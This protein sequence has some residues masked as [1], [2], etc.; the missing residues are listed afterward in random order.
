MLTGAALLGCNL[1][2]S[3]RTLISDLSVIAATAEPTE[4]A[5]GEE[6]L[7]SM[8]VVDPDRLGVDQVLVWTCADLG[9]GCAEVFLVESGAGLATVAPVADEQAQVTLV[10][11]SPLALVFQEGLDELSLPLYILACAPGACPIFDQVAADPAVGTPEF[12]AL[13]EALGDPESLV[14]GLPM[15]QACLA[16]RD[17]LISLRGEEERNHNPLLVGPTEE[18]T[19]VPDE[20][21]ALVFSVGDPDSEEEEATVFL[22]PLSTLGTFD[23][24]ALASAS[25]DVTLSFLAPDDIDGLGLYAVVRDGL[26]GQTWWRGEIA[27]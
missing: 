23:Q 10:V 16:E 13:A 21:N 25:G 9:E 5:P 1:D 7:L 12:E 3:P 20:S 27:E 8:L 19:I 14:S 18:L 2:Q 11:P 15:D 4:A 17:L 22:S 26:G 24:E 6:I